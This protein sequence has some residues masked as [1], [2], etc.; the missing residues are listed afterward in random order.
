M[1][2]SS[3]GLWR[4]GSSSTGGSSCLTGS[5]TIGF[6]WIGTI[7]SFGSS[8]NGKSGMASAFSLGGAG[9]AGAVKFSFATTFGAGSLCTSSF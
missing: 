5:S 4:Y 3:V 9:H 6:S 7:S 2:D 1:I 8:G